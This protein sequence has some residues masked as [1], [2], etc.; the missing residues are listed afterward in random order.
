M[1]KF[2]L[3]TFAILFSIITSKSYA[4]FFEIYQAVDVEK[5][6]GK[7]FILEGKIF[8][9]D[10]IT[11]SSWAVL[12][13]RSI[14]A[15]GKQ[16]KQTFYNDNAS[17]Y[18]K[19]NEWSAYELSGKI[20]KGAKYLATSIAI[21][22]N[23]SYYLD[24]FKL[25]IKDGKNKIEI[26]LKNGDFETNTI[27]NW[28]SM[29]LDKNTKLTLSKEKAY[30][31][32]Q[33]LFIDNSKVQSAPTLGNNST[34]GKYAE[35]NGIKLYYEIY[36]EGEPLL[37]LHGNNS[38][39]ASFENQ[40]EILSKKYKVIALDSRGQGK[41]TGDSKKITYELMAKDVNELLQHLQ[42]KNVNILGWSDGGN[43]ALIVAMQYPDKVK[44]MAVMGTVLFNNDSSVTTETN[45]LIRKQVK[46]M[47]DKGVDES[48][49]DYRLKMLLL[50]EPNIN[51]DS[52]K[53]IQAP[54]LVIAGQYDV[55]KEK[56]SKLI[57]E[58]I[59]NSKLLIFKGADHEAPKKI[60]QLFNKAVLDFFEK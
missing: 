2:K 59:Q 26:P 23:D 27:L 54:T 45:T 19:K 6:Q 31:G 60:P 29:G 38:S 1:L 58:K 28:Q 20:E 11:N 46:E 35:V 10:N 56:H 32:A 30:S 50:T 7:N 48:N 22:G 5:Y 33:S 25:F 37:L 8:Y 49:M 52:L 18:F 39:I 12:G 15:D 4:Q 44:K 21:S 53:K 43:I 13:A 36:G 47:R 34:V 40:V 51:P 41:S 3:Y 16:L 9:M 42:L 14:N 57:A 55:V 17:D 24:D